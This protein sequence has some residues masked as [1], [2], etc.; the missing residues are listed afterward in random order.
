MLKIFRKTS[1]ANLS[2]AL[3]K[4]TA[5]LT[6]AE[7]AVESAQAA[8]DA[9]LLIETPTK[10]HALVDGNT[11]DRLRHCQWRYPIF[12]SDCFHRSCYRQ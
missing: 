8:Y 11:G 5:D 4:A 10:L 12:T 9:G 6:T 1:S 3:A 7:A 2:A